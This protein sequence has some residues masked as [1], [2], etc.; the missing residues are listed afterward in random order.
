MKRK[1]SRFAYIRLPFEF[2]VSQHGIGAIVWAHQVLDMRV[3][4]GATIRRS[5]LMLLLVVKPPSTTVGTGRPWR[6]CG[7]AHAPAGR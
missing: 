5:V 2:A 3:P 1:P 6:R 7:R 4:T